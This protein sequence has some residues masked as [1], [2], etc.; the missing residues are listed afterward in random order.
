MARHSSIAT[1]R[2][3]I[4]A[5]AV[6]GTLIFVM[7]LAPIPQDLEYHRFVDTRGLFGIPNAGDV[8]S[9]LPFLLAGLYGLKVIQSHPPGAMVRAWKV[10]FVGVALV[11]FGS[12]YYHWAPD[13]ASLVW[14]RLPMT[15]GFMG[16]FV[17]LSGEFVDER[18][19]SQLLI[20]MILVGFASVVVWAMTDDLRFYAWVQGM[21]LLVI[22][23]YLAVFRSA[24]S[25][26]AMLLAAL[27][28]YV[29]A[30]VTESYDAVVFEAMGGLLSGHSIKHL[31][32]AGGCFLLGF[33][34]KVRRPFASTAA[35]R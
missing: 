34:V 1:W 4:L 10:L 33:Y 26:R 6:F 12:A 17:A 21:P 3:V 11:S 14:D 28:L 22:L 27:L 31:L 25:H 29:L 7:S 23:V 32:A 2:L 18:R 16:L 5:L 15:I 8:L 30:K 35:A 19:A 20:P 13:N 24:Y 9:N